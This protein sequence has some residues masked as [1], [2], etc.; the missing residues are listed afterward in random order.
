MFILPFIKDRR[1]VNEVFIMQFDIPIL[2]KKEQEEAV[3]KIH[4]LM[5]EGIS[6]Q[7]AIK[8]IADQLREKYKN[9]E[10]EHIIFDDEDD[11]DLEE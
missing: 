9:K 5:R 2:V 11:E 3:E 4:E 1:Y 10:H 7:D 6:S 8:A